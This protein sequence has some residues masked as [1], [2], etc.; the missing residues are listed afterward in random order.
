[1]SS[2]EQKDKPDVDEIVNRAIEV[3]G[4]DLYNKATV[5]FEFRKKRYRAKHD[6]G[7][8]WYKREFKDSAKLI[9]DEITNTGFFRSVNGL[10]VELPQKD[11]TKYSNSVN[12]VIYFA[13][14]PFKLN[15]AAVQ[16]EYLGTSEVK[17][18]SYYK[19]KVTFSK[20]GGG[21]DYEDEFIYWI[22]TDN[23]T[24][25]YLAYEFHI[26][27]GGTRFREAIQPR[28]INGIRFSDYINYKYPTMDVPLED[29]DKLL[30][31]GELTELSRI[32][33]ENIKVEI[34]H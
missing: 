14:L 12:S 13:L 23:F 17:S 29:Y 31:S 9:T 5:D 33:N 10:P 30:E 27:K 1:M 20:E 26:D 3:H 6:G 7:K 24:V 18:K 4:G 22:S 16:R 11:K 8:Y 21:T 34:S 19:V 2:C 28:V 32:I 15:D 25:D